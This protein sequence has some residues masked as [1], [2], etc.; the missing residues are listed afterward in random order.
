MAD[1]KPI[2]T[3]ENVWSAHPHHWV[4]VGW[5]CILYLYLHLYFSFLYF[6]VF[7]HLYFI[8]VL[9]YI[10]FLYL[11]NLYLHFSTVVFLFVFM[12]DLYLHA[13]KWYTN[14]NEH[15]SGVLQPQ[16]PKLIICFW[17]MCICIKNILYSYSCRICICICK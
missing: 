5:V 4:M 14:I 11:C 12:W 16:K 8:F 1:I 2:S 6:F 13:L 17:H 10:L 15:L 9:V 7:L 3:S